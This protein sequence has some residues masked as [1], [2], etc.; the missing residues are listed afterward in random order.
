MSNLDA[1][2]KQLAAMAATLGELTE[3]VEGGDAP[4][5]SA[6]EVTL[7][8]F[9]STNLDGLKSEKVDGQYRNTLCQF[10]N[11]VRKCDECGVVIVPLKRPAQ[12]TAARLM[13]SRNCPKC[14]RSCRTTPTAHE[15]T[16]NLLGA[17]VSVCISDGY[18]AVTS[19]RWLAQI[20]A[21]L[22]DMVDR[23]IDG[24]RAPRRMTGLPQGARNIQ[25]VDPAEIRAVYEAC[26]VAKLWDP[27]FWRTLIVGLTCYG[28]RIGEI[29]SI[30]WRGVKV[31]VAK[32]GVFFGKTPP[33]VQLRLAGVNHP[34]GWL[35]YVPRKQAAAKPDPLILPLSR[36]FRQHLLA[37]RS[38]KN[39]TGQV[40]PISQE[41]GNYTLREPEFRAEFQRIRLAAGVKAKWTFKSLRATCETF[42]GDQFGSDDAKAL[43]GHADRTVSGQSYDEKSKRFCRQVDQFKLN[44]LFEAK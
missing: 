20:R 36:V 23:G 44:E 31:G 26:E 13:R 28:F 4:A 16:T 22:N 10:Q 3:P 35:V 42:Y 5:P 32:E 8:D 17:W 15:L 1:L 43:T 11:R 37:A 27:V 2:T 38:L 6:G 18:S 30:K 9:W 40:L 39:E 14:S 7:Y 12:R 19:R 25:L 24:V 33:T 21:V 29:T 41:A 34:H